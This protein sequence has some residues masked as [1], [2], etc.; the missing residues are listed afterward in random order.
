MLYQSFYLETC[1]LLSPFSVHHY[2]DPF[3][4]LHLLNKH[5]N[6]NHHN[7][8]VKN[9]FDNNNNIEDACI[10]LSSKL[11]PWVRGRRQQANQHGAVRPLRLHLHGVLFRPWRRRIA[12]I[13]QFLQGKAV[14]YSM[15]L[16]LLMIWPIDK[17]VYV[18]KRCWRRYG[19]LL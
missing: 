16:S 4:T 5:N 11:H 2:F 14:T 6:N 18:H 15:S 7:A 17:S 8:Y 10:C 9:H 13:P 12:W 19:L 1:F 3:G